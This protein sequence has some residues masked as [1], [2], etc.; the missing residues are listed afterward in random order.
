MITSLDM[1]ICFLEI[2]EQK[3]I[4]KLKQEGSAIIV[5]PSQEAPTKKFKPKGAIEEFS[6]FSEYLKNVS[7]ELQQHWLETY[8][9]VDAIK[10]KI[11]DLIRWELA[12]PQ[13]A[14]KNKGA[15][16][17]NCLGRDLKPANVLQSAMKVN[18]DEWL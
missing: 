16:I 15:F 13:K 3:G 10:N 9:D 17:N 2:C 14:K 18:S 5:I 4:V 8:R 6:E 12:N 1:L 7:Q 11:R